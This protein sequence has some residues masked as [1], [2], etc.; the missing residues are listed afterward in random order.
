M[1]LYLDDIS[2]AGSKEEIRK[3]VK[4]TYSKDQ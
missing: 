1:W 2:A 4:A 3:L